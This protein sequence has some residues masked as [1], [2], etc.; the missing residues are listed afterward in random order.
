MLRL[1]L[2]TSRPSAKRIWALLSILGLCVPAAAGAEYYRYET[3]NGSVAFTDDPDQIPARY[4]ESA[5]TLAEKSVHDF[6]RTTRVEPREKA[7]PEVSASPPAPRRVYVRPLPAK[8][9]RVTIAAGEGID[10]DVETESAEPIIVQKG[11]LKS[12]GRGTAEHTIVKQGDKVLM[13]VREPIVNWV[14][15]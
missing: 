15:P 4:R 12:D 11:V 9:R 10:F 3:E 2:L 6:S 8:P 14:E 5:E 1:N 13:E 7:T